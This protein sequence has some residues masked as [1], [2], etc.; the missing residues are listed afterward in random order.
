MSVMRCCEHCGA[1]LPPRAPAGLCPKCLLR[2]AVQAPAESAQ[3]AQPASPA[4]L[5]TDHSSLPA[6]FGDYELLEKIAAGGMGVVYKARQ[7]SLNRVVAVKMIQPGRLAGEEMVLRFRAEAEAAAS[8]QHPHIVAIHETGE[9][10]GQHYFSMDY[11]AGTNLADAVRSQSLPPVRAAQVLKAITEAVHYAHQKG[12]LHR[13]LKPSNII[14]DEAGEPHVTDFGLAKRLGGDSELTLTGQVLGSPGFMPPE[15]ATGQPSRVDV[16]SDVYGL[17]AILYY[18]LTGRPPFQAATLT[19]T[20]KQLNEAEPISPRLLNPSVPKDLATICLKCL[21]KEMPRRYPSAQGLTEELGRFLRGEPILARPIGLVGKAGRWCRRNPRLAGM[22]AALVLS[23]GLGLMAVLYQWQQAERQRLSAVANELLARQNA[24]AADMLLAQH[25]LTVN[26]R[27]LAVSLLDK[28]RPRGKAESRKQKAEIDLRHWEWRYLW[29]LCQGDEWFTLHQYPV[30][31]GPLALSKDG[32]VLALRKGGEVALWDLDIKRPLRELP[33]AAT[34]A[35]AFSPTGS[36]LAV[37]SRDAAGQ[38]GIDLWDVSTGQ[39]TKTL[40]HKAEVRSV[41]FSPDAKLLATFDNRGG[42]AV[43]E[44]GFGNTLTNFDLRPPRHR[45][46]GV[47]AFSPDGSRL[48]VGEDYGGIHLLSLRAGT[49][50]QVQMPF[51]DGTS[52]LVFSPDADVLAAAFGAI[53]CLYDARS[54]EALGQLTNH[55]EWV[56]GLAFTPD[57]RQLASASS[58]GT[59]RIWSVADRSELR[60]LWSSREGLAGLALLPD[61]KTLVSG[62]WAGSVCFWD[63]AGSHQALAHTNLAISFGFESQADVARAGYAPGALDPKVVRRL[64]VAF[65][66]DSRTFITTDPNGILGVWEVQPLRQIET[67][68]ALGS[69]HWGVA[70]SAD[71]RWLA[72]GDTGGKLTIWDWTTRRAVTNLALPF[73][74]FGHLRFSRSGHYLLAWVV[75]NETVVQTRI[76]QIGDWHE[77]PLTQRQSDRLWSKDLS[78]DDRLLATGYADG[79][80][81]LWQFPSGEWE[82]TFTNHSAGVFETLFSPDGRVLISTSWD[83]SIRLCDVATRRKLATL[84]GHSSIVWGAALS[85]DGRRLATGGSS[86]R[87]AVKLWDLEAHRELLS[88]QGEG[89]LFMHLTFSPDGNTLAATSLDGVAHLWRAPS[90]AEIEAAEKRPL[91]PATLTESTSTKGQTQ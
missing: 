67:L 3:A 60:C 41:A 37:G 70:L 31:V 26:N 17:G 89:K 90:W 9:C 5:V 43:V 45:P 57:G 48:A 1:V 38:P 22:T 91:T 28:H 24:Y 76:W 12:I 32:K 44:L 80:V 49:V 13:D 15:Q 66:P 36:L 30:S 29:Q 18:V 85:P 68:S 77:I 51:N 54:G 82:A 69:N 58:D 8:L 20:L 42:V 75:F 79:A 87:D 84:R 83:T 72:A 35:L 19:D 65:A 64:G 25:A 78:Y 74:W 14:L 59:I 11:V 53:I 50:V 86:S 81:K 21:E 39:L 34:G 61:G 4:S 10:G 88:L 73:E 2:Q 47:V 63:A 52:T 33:N 46:A 27:A 55:T 62:G 16:R 40:P 7:R 6:H 56:S 71:G 23:L